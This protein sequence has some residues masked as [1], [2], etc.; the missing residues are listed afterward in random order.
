MFAGF[1]SVQ[2]LDFALFFKKFVTT[3]ILI[4]TSL[5]STRTNAP[6]SVISVGS[7][8]ENG[9]DVVSQRERDIT[10][11]KSVYNPILFMFLSL[12]YTAWKTAKEI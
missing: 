12:N 7:V 11:E 2:H 1:F 10:V 9:S 6:L 3:Q 8:V 4:H 5:P